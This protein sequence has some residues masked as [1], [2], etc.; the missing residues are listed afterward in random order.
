[1]KDKPSSPAKEKAGRKKPNI[2][3]RLLAFLVT[4]ALIVGAVVLVVYRDRLNFDAVKRYFTYRSLERSDSG[5][6][7]SFAHEGSVADAFAAVNGNLL[8]A[9]STGVRLYSGSGVKYVDEQAALQRPVVCTAGAWSLAYDAGG[10]TLFVFKNKALVFSPTLDKGTTLL[11]ARLNASGYLAV[12]TQ[13]KGYKGS[14]TVYN[15]S[16][17]QVLQVN[18][19]SLFVMDALVTADNKA[20]A[21]V[22]V[23]QGDAG[24]ESRLAFFRLD[25][26]EEETEPDFAYSLGS[27]IVL[28]LEEDGAGLWALGDSG[29]SAVKTDGTPLG[30]FDYG[31]RYLKEY[32]LGGDGFA[33]TLLGKYRAGT[34]ADLVT[35]GP[36]GTQFA[37]LS[38]NEQVLS[39]SAA[40]RYVAVLTADRLDIYTSDLTP[41]ST[42]E[43]IQGARKVLMRSDGTALLIASDTARLYIPS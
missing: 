16:F 22:T 37:T 17:E 34:L 21:A 8:A 42:L 7:E 20:L 30:S 40:G 12:T 2:F 19:S 5:Q 10:E 3:V 11:S 18:R 32:S 26:T 15:P 9:S 33:A 29:L 23:G 13:A 25:R 31:G 1:M 14:V 41:Y 4:L 35:A 36:D 39:L 27:R 28:E 43:G 38:L 24:F 6:A